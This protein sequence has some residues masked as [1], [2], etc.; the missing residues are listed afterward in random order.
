MVFD[1]HFD[2]GGSP[3]PPETSHKTGEEPSNCFVYDPRVLFEDC[4]KSL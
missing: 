3:T 1:D 4:Q 2:L